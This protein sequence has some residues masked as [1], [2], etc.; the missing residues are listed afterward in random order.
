MKS[1]KSVKIGNN[2]PI[3][4]PRS[5]LAD[6]TSVLADTTSDCG[7][8][9]YATDGLLMATPPPLSIVARALLPRFTAPP[10]GSREEFEKP[11]LYLYFVKVESRFSRNRSSLSGN[12]WSLH[13]RASKFPDQKLRKLLIC[14]QT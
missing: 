11:T 6:V 3:N 13:I 5:T 1:E 9:V 4:R 14:C 10:R 7:V 2:Q 12:K 8:Q